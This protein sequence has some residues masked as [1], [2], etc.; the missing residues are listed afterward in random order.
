M[1][2]P[3]WLS[4]GGSFDGIAEVFAIGEGEFVPV[5]RER[6]AAIRAHLFAADVQFVGA[7]LGGGGRSLSLVGC[8]WEVGFE[9]FEET[10]GPA[11][12]PES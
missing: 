5:S 6:V 4:S 3:G 2:S 8:G 10:I 7:I 9:V 11:F 1:A 12:S